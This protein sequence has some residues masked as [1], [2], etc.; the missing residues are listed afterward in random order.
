[1]Y[2]GVLTLR[3]NIPLP[4]PLDKPN[5]CQLYACNFKLVFSANSKFHFKIAENML[6]AGQG[7]GV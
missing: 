3:A 7:G 6:D 4:A 1:M 2:V 5:I